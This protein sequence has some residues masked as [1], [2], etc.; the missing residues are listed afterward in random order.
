MKPE[1]RRWA[2]CLA[3]L[4]SFLGAAAGPVTD[5]VRGEGSTSLSG[6]SPRSL[7]L[8]RCSGCH[9]PDGQGALSAGVPPFAGFMGP[10]TRDSGGRVYVTHVPGIAGSGLS[11]AQVADVLNYVL[12]DLSAEPPEGRRRFTAAEI[13]RLRAESVTDVVAYRRGVVAR[14]SRQGVTPAAYPWP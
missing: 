13:G 14:L 11:D 1:Q 9:R 2:A 8:L 7:Y 6:M 4:A 10:L 5:G 12:D 3:A